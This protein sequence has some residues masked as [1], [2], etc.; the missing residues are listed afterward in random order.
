MA[1]DTELDD[2]GLDDPERRRLL[3]MALTGSAAPPAGPLGAGPDTGDQPP[4]VRQPVS[5]P[6]RTAAAAPEPPPI[7][8][9]GPATM[10]EQTLL[11]Q[12]PPQY[13][14]WRRALDILGRA[15]APGR[16]IEE[17]TGLGTLGYQ[18]RLG[19][20]AGA[21]NEEEKRAG[22]PVKAATDEAKLKQFDMVPLKVPWQ[23]EPIYVQRKD[24]AGIER[25]ILSGQTARATTTEKTGSQEKIA[26]GKEASQEKIATG[27]E[28]STEKIAGE[29]IQSAEDIAQGNRES[30][31][32]IATG[33]NLAST[34]VARIRAAS[35]ND[36][37]KLTNTMKTM[38][39]QAQATLPGINR[40]L[41]ETEKVANLLGPGE[42]RWN[43]FMTGKIGGGDPV[44][45]HYRDEIGMV[46]SAVTLAHARGRMSNELFEHFERMFNAGKL[47]AA[48]MIQALN[49]AHEWL[50]DYATMGEGPGGGAAPAP[51][52]PKGVPDA[53]VWNEQARKWQMPTAPKP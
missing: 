33:H 18:S 44:Y 35:A 24:A 15:T 14:G 11:Q 19:Q 38:K 4:P 37:N 50:S 2:I 41:D 36:P 28:A 51:Q 12:G 39:Q 6:A 1:F 42:G 10:R 20:A 22:A 34:E 43:D 16:T 53:A 29:K 7:R 46:Q 21:A 3:G 48:N 27:K 52:R 25:Q 23:D 49:V 5:L 40:A 45:K 13:H 17:G 32:R 8:Q 47:S 30:K 31:E 26:T 9:P